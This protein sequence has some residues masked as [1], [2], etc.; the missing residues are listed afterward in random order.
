MSNPAP[1]RVRVAG[2]LEPFVEGFRRELTDQGYASSPAAGHLQLMAHLSRWL[3]DRELGPD[4]LCGA[5][6]EQFLEDRHGRGRVHRRLTLAGLRPLLGYLRGL[7]VVPGLER[8]IP[9]GPLER[10]VEEFTGYLIDERGLAE[11]TVS[12]YRGVALLFLRACA[13]DPGG[14]RLMLGDLAADDVIGFV[15]AEAYRLSAGSLSNVATGLRALLRFLYVQGYTATSLAPAVPTAPGWRDEGLPR[16]AELAQ[17]AGLLASCDRRCASGRRDFAILTLLARL[18][19]RA[20]EVAM[21][22][23]DDVDWRAGELV[24]TGKGNRRERLPLPHDVGQAIADYCQRGRRQGGCRSLFLHARAPYVAVSASGV[25]QVVARACD[26]AGLDRMGAH[27]LRHATA[28]AMRRAG[29]PLFE[30]GQVL[31]HRHASTTAHYA[32]DDLDALVIV[33]RRWLGGAA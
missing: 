22:S 33:A 10:L 2:P 12:S 15:L 29:A 20:G 4:G 14:G 6:V 18:G 27:Q 7:G 26:R 19:L 9:I 1:S 13:C 11:Q 21:L 24:V 23:V 28:T 8:P 30:I 17:V 25:R 31:R 16:A 32:R 5:R 3:A